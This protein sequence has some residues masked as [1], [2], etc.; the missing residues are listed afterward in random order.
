[1]SYESFKNDI[2]VELGT[3]IKLNIHISPIDGVTIDDYDYTTEVYCTPLKNIIVPKS[4]TIRVDNENYI[5]R[6]DTN[7]IGVGKIVCR[8]VAQ[9]PDGD[10]DDGY[11]TEVV[12]IMTNINVVKTK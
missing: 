3:E 1:M 7:V 5:V 12:A 8:I 4:E 11:R 6:V 9:I 2:L 10:F